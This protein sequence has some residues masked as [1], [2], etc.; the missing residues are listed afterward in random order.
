MHSE[1]NLF[2]FGWEPM[3]PGFQGFFPVYCEVCELEGDKKKKK[4]LSQI[5]SKS[6][7]YHVR[8]KKLS[9]L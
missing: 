8:G 7:V 2:Q 5:L 3:F 1:I 9:R 4:Q 6:N